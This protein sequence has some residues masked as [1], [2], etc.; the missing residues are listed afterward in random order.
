LADRPALPRQ[1]RRDVL[2]E[3]GHR[4]AIPTCKQHPVDI[5]HIEPRKANGSNDV[6]DNLIALCGNCHARFDRGQI[7]RTAMRQYK[8]NLSV[9]NHRYGDLERRVLQGFADDDNRTTIRLPGGLKIMLQFLLQDGYIVETG[10][11]PAPVQT[12]ASFSGMPVI[13]YFA[14]TD[15]GRRFIDRWLR[16][17]DLEQT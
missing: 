16:A 13:E 11:P 2:V 8:A 17:E 9:L 7:D 3:A 12:Y 5:A 6:F 4:C 14:I 1:L 15:E 10:P